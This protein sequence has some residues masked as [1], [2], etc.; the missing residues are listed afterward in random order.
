[1]G[2]NAQML[3]VTETFLPVQLP[4]TFTTNTVNYYTNHSQVWI[5][6]N[7]SNQIIHHALFVK[8]NTIGRTSVSLEKIRWMRKGKQ[9]QRFIIIS[10]A[11]FMLSCL[12]AYP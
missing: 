3:S 1:M 2:D 10:K 11:C 6:W 4:L 7:H 8:V 5:S 12:C 9:K